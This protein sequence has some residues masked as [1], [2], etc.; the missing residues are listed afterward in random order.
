VLRV[1]DCVRIHIA[2]QLAHDLGLIVDQAEWLVRHVLPVMLVHCRVEVPDEQ[3][4]LLVLGAS[5]VTRRDKVSINA[6]PGK[7]IASA[8]RNL[9]VAVDKFLLNSIWDEGVLLA[10]ARVTTLVAATKAT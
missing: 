1:H 9:D 10:M 7:S 2:Y 6:I 3:T 4:T 8:L 5:L